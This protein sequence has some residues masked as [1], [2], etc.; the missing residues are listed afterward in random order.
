MIVTKIEAVTKTR[1][2]VYLDGRFAFALYK[3]ELSKYHISENVD[4]P[5]ESYLTIRK[6]VVLKRAKLRA[7]HLLSDMDRTENQLRTKLTQGLCPPD[8]VDEAVAYVKSFGYIDDAQYARR[9][10]GSRKEKKS[11]K[12][13]YA[14]LCQKG[15]DKETVEAVMEE[16]YEPG[17]SRLAI[18]QL[19][20]KKKYHPDTATED[21][22]RKI[23]AFLMRKGF[24]YEDVRQVI[25]VSEWNA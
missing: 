23:L 15:I 17:D 22:K 16:C 4:L 2:K 5:E 3:G 10:V 13:I 8:I 1:H 9:F 14:A 21:E 20:K 12:E 19:M 18:E 24:K 7:M 6:D 25:Q 11:R